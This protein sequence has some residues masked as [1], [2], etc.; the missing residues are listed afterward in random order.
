MPS[1][2]DAP[3]AKFHEGGVGGYPGAT[4]FFPSWDSA[5]LG[6]PSQPPANCPLRCYNL[7]PR[8]K[9]SHVLHSLPVAGWTR[10]GQPTEGQGSGRRVCHAGLTH[11]D[12]GTREQEV[13]IVFPGGASF[14][15]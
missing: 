1:E 14:P 11:G 15:A 13:P 5:L 3:L 9:G 6:R 12:T 2:L 7:A 4:S 8:G 10:H